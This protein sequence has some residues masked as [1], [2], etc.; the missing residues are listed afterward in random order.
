MGIPGKIGIQ[1]VDYSDRHFL[2]ALENGTITSHLWDMTRSIKGMF[3]HQIILF[4]HTIPHH[5]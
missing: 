3:I 4:V 5:P 2:V 1:C